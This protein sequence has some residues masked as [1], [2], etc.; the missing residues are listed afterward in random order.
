MSR[1]TAGNG[2]TSLARVAVVAAG[3]ISPLG[4]GLIETLESLRAARD[5]VTP[6]RR[7]SVERCR[8]KTA[9]QVPDRWLEASEDGRRGRRMHRAS[10]MLIAALREALTQ[11]RQFRPEL[12]VIGTTS[13]GMSYGEDY[14]RALRKHEKLRHSP[15]WIANYPPQKPVIDAQQMFAISAPCEVIANACASG[16]NAIGHAFEC[17]RSGRYERVLTGGYD[18]LS[19]LVFVGF[20]SLQASTPE[21]CRPFDRD[22]SGMVLGEGA[23]ILALE[24]LETARARGATILGEINGYGIS[25]DNFHLTQ[26]N[27]SGIAARQAMERALGNAGI[28]A[29]SIDYV[30]AHGTATLLNDAAEGKAIRELL[31]KTPVSSTKSMM[32]HSLGAAGAIEA[33]VCLLALQHQFLPP[34]INFRGTDQDVDLAIVAN[35]SRPAELRTALSNSFGFGGANASI[36]MQKFGE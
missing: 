20:D 25:T 36:V 9:G 31:G 19:E 22:R 35:E 17:V 5:C 23:A 26:P 32:G 12:T 2:K 14:Y 8:C 18:A 4:N 21:K 1:S 11:D 3:V 10:H 16:T 30:N 33:I 24:N 15:R 13:G 29:G 7:F 6:V 34:N 28:S 27:P